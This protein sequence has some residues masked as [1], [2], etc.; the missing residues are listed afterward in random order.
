MRGFMKKL[1]LILPVVIFVGIQA[2]KD[3]HG[4]DIFY[5]ISHHH[6]D[7]PML[8][9]LM[10]TMDNNAENKTQ[11]DLL[12]QAH[13]AMLSKPIAEFVNDFKTWPKEDQDK[14]EI[15]NQG[16]MIEGRP[17]AADKYNGNIGF[18]LDCRLTQ[19]Q[20]VPFLSAIDYL[21]QQKKNENERFMQQFENEDK[22]Y[23]GP[24]GKFKK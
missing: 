7:L 1:L 21:K 11:E 20:I 17:A 4:E 23:V 12:F 18:Y 5:A 19:K 8:D 15:F 22:Q 24:T 10:E 16:F 9:E 13:V 14:I 2:N 6:I 3:R